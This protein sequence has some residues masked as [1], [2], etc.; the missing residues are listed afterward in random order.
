MG[1]LHIMKTKW[2][3]CSSESPKEFA[4][5]LRNIHTIDESH[6]EKNIIWSSTAINSLSSAFQCLYQ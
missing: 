6:T 4:E 2:E 3:K 1:H 5:K